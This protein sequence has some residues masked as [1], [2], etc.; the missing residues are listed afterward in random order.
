MMAWRWNAEATGLVS[1]TTMT[2]KIPRPHDRW[3]AP[4]TSEVLQAIRRLGRFRICVAHPKGT[5]S[6]WFDAEFINASNKSSPRPFL[7]KFEEQFS[8]ALPGMRCSKVGV[9][10]DVL[11]KKDLTGDQQEDQIRIWQEP[12]SDC[13]KTLV[14]GGPWTEDLQPRDLRIGG[15]ARSAF[16]LRERAAGFVQMIKERQELDGA[17]PLADAGGV[18]RFDGSERAALNGELEKHPSVRKLVAAICGPSPDAK[19]AYDAAYEMLHT[20][21]ALTTFISN[22]YR[23]IAAAGDAEI[24]EACIAAFMAA[25][26]DSRVTAKGTRRPWLKNT[27][28]ALLELNTTTLDLTAPLQD[29]ENLWAAGLDLS[30]LLDGGLWFGPQDYPAPPDQVNKALEMVRLEGSVEEA[31]ERVLQLLREAQE[32]RQWSVPWGARVQ[33]S[34]GP[35]ICMKVHE[36]F[37]EFSCLFLDDKDRYL[38][39]AIGLSK[40]EPRI[41]CQAFMRKADDSDEMVWNDDAEVSLEL[42]AAAI[43]RDFLV[44]EEREKVFSTRPMRRRVNGR[45]ISTIV[46]LPR[47]RYSMPRTSGPDMSTQPRLRTKHAV[48][49]HLRRAGTASATQRFMAQRYGVQLPQGFTFVRPHERGTEAEADRVRIYRS[50]SAS[51]MLFEEIVSAPEGPR[52]QWFDFERD[53]A[54]LL[55]SRRMRVIHQAAH[56]DGDGGVDL[57]AVDANEQSWVVQCKC[58]SPHRPVGPDVVRELVGAVTSA[59]RGSPSKSRGMIITTSRFTSGAVSEAV[60]NGFLLMDGEA[61]AERLKELPSS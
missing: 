2:T 37:G 7:D 30:D 4:D 36:Y 53:C 10:Y 54:K 48:S 38:H 21:P 14:G 8:W 60:A 40:E 27:D 61:F 5:R 1:F 9:R 43:V 47:V 24:S 58:W 23:W 34:F 44:V 52:P 20:P 17:A 57:F 15:W 18:W 3:M 35:F 56:R 59:D 28:E 51:K 42:I 45:Q 33:V 41:S 6:G 13:W 19:T 50:R 46:Y 22:V 11:N 32:A 49:Y 16:H 31:R 26:Q 29:V 25:L 39:V 12:V 55:A